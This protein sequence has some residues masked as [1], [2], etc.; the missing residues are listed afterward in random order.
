MFSLIILLF[1]E[2][3]AFAEGG[4]T[5]SSSQVEEGWKYLSTEEHLTMVYA[6]QRSGKYRSA[7][8]RLRFLLAQEA[9]SI[10]LR[11]EYAKNAEY[12]EKYLEAA[13]IYQTLLQ[14][15]LPSDVKLN[16]RYRYCIVLSDGTPASTI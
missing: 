2:P 11:F 16:V 13:D 5:T 15:K 3:L 8:K 1:L 10:I 12:Q 4:E 9:S 14:E 7:D 6:L